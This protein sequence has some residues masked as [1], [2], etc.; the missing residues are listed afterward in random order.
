MSGDGC[1]VFVS[2]MNRG[3][4]KVAGIAVL[5]RKG[6]RLD[7]VRTVPM[8]EPLAGIVLTH[9]GKML[10]AAAIDKVM[11][12]DVPCLISGCGKPIAGSF[13]DG[14]NMQ[15]IYANVTSDDKLLF[16]SEEAGSAITV[17]DL[18]HARGA[19]FRADSIIGKIPVGHA[20][21]AL[22]FS[23]DG[24]WLF[25][26]SQAALKE[27]GWPAACKP[28]GRPNVSDLLNPEGAVVVVDVER[29]K[30]N[31]ANAV[32]ARD[33]RGMQSG[34]HGDFAIGRPDLRD[35][36]QQQRGGG[37]RRRQADLRS[38]PLQVGDG[39]RGHRSGADR[40]GG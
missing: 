14:R 5:S 31:P 24:R 23:P 37:L 2:M 27:W 8:P 9:D 22:T 17:I 32:A 28:E 15:S 40:R 36:A 25:T 12:L 18:G 21:I 4:G 30:S 26:T 33:S 34:A 38:G 6:G 35:R 19:G 39:D 16:V 3:G 1:H 20:P 10:I 29:A 13:S 11:F 7:L